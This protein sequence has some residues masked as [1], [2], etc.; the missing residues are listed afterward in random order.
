MML[1]IKEKE[2]LGRS[3]DDDGETL[4]S[5][6]R[7]LTNGIL[8]KLE[9]VHFGKTHADDPLPVRVK[10]LR[11]HLIDAICEDGAT[12]EK[13]AAA[14]HALDEV[15]LVLQLYSYPGDY[16]ASKPS[17]ERMAETIEK[18]E[19]DVYDDYAKPRGRVVRRSRSAS[20][21][22]S[23][24]SPL[25]GSKPVRRRGNSRCSSNRPCRR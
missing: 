19:E 8:E 10:Q 7:R 3:F 25:P 12:P 6:I 15:H 11:R 1:T 4:P 5:R 21:S 9:T 23:N 20:R 2:K 24:R 16:V 13:S 14:H 22:T 18:F 17:P